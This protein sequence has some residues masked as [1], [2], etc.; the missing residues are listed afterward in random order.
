METRR[1]RKPTV[2]VVPARRPMP[3]TQAAGWSSLPIAIPTMPY[4]R[5]KAVEP[6]A[7]VDPKNPGGCGRTELAGPTRRCLNNL[8]VA[9]QEVRRFERAIAVHQDTTAIRR[10][11]GDR[12]RENEPEQ[13]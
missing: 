11:T 10:E 5:T 6:N 13:P 9:L 2:P 4:S 12:H 7:K 8:N 1:Y 3:T